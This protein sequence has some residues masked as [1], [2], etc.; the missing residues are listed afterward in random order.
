M[1]LLESVP[2]VSEGRD[3]ALIEELGAAFASGGAVLV[4]T[5]TDARHHRSVFT[6]LGDGACARGR[7]ARGDRARPRRH[8]S[9]RSMREPTRGSGSSTSCRSSRSNPRDALARATAAHV[10]RAS[11]S[12]TSSGCRSSSTGS[13]A[14]G[15]RPAFYR[16][17]GLDE[18]RRRVDAGE[19]EPALRARDDRRPV[20]VRSSSVLALPSSPTTSSSHGSLDVAREIAAAVRATSGGLPGVQALGLRLDDGTVQVSTNVVDLDATAP[21]ELVERSSREAARRGVE[22]GAGELVGLVPASTVAGRGRGGLGRARAARCRRLADGFGS[23]AAAAA[24]CDSIGS[25]P[26][27]CIEWHVARLARP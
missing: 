11:A 14:A 27:A 7:A 16:R 2:N 5:H 13:L 17:G 10:G 23:P 12:G 9:P 6:L 20:G 15:R 3:A 24:P 22:V 19:L 18:L 4:D 8:R 25:L 21:H 26:T 1:T